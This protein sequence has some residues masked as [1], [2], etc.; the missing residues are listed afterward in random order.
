VSSVLRAAVTAKDQ[1]VSGTPA[2]WPV[3][4]DKCASPARAKAAVRLEGFWSKSAIQIP[5]G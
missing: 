1:A 3:Q 4:K 2:E 5:E